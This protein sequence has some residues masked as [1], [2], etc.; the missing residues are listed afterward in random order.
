[1][2]TVKS[3]PISFNRKLFGDDVRKAR[4]E[5]GLT[6]DELGQLVGLSNKT[7]SGV[8]TGRD[9]Y[10]TVRTLEQV[11]NALDLNPFSRRYVVLD[12]I[13]KTR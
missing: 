7:I 1:M 2:K 3:Y 8:E 11:A 10:L 9:G 6:Q 12:P 5:S 4:L 13:S